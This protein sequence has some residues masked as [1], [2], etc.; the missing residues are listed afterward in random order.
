M[1]ALA[2]AD[3]GVN[4]TV[5]EFVNNGGNSPTLSRFAA[6]QIVFTQGT[7]DGRVPGG[8][9]VFVWNDFGTPT[10]LARINLDS[11]QPDSG[12]LAT[13]AAAAVNVAGS[14]GTINDAQP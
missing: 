5:P 6:P 11:S 4:W 1:K 9:L 12:V 10:A 13:K 3:G 2:S 14:T 7:S 8:Q